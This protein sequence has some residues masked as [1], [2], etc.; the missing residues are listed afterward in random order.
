LILHTPELCACARSLNN[1]VKLR[2]RVRV[3][4][5]N[6]FISE[7]PVSEAVSKARNFLVILRDP[8]HCNIGTLAYDISDR[9]SSLYRQ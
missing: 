3:I 6:E 4:P 1:M 9:Y 5:E 8:E 2:V 7:V